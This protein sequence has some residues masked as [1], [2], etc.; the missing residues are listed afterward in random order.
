MAGLFIGFLVEKCV[1]CHSDGI[2][3]VF[4]FFK[5]SQAMLALLDSF[6]EL[7]LKFFYYYYLISLSRAQFMRQICARL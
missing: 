2:V 7:Y 4:H 6:Q 5:N 3:F 1:A